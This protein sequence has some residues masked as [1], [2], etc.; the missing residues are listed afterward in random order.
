MK[1]PWIVIVT[2]KLISNFHPQTYP[3]GLSIFHHNPLNLEAW[4][5]SNSNEFHLTY[6]LI[7]IPS[8]RSLIFS[9]PKNFIYLQKRR[10]IENNK[11]SVKRLILH[12]DKLWGKYPEW[13]LSLHLSIRQVRI[14][15]NTQ[16]QDLFIQNFK[17]KKKENHCE[18]ISCHNLMKIIFSFTPTAISHAIKF[19][20]NSTSR[21]MINLRKL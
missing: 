2:E 13:T 12:F 19:P 6:F 14:I 5:F 10:R 11:I 17:N 1:R 18:N 16:I 7:L 8:H 21:R 3:R 9:H 4:K 20:W 15:S